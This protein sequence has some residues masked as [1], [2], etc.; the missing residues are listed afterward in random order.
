[1]KRTRKLLAAAL[2]AVL[3]LTILSGCSQT[4]NI[5]NTIVTPAAEPDPMTAYYARVINEKLNREGESS[6]SPFPASHMALMAG[7]KGL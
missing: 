6:F 3:A 5:Y 1:M 4:E 2:A 7:I